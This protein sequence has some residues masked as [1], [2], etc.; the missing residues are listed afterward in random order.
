MKLPV[1]ALVWPDLTLAA[2]AIWG[3]SQ[4]MEDVSISLSLSFKKINPFFRKG[5]NHEV[6]EC[7]FQDTFNQ[8]T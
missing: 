7:Y 1:L 4:G 2:V 3:V 6:A 8:A 5:I